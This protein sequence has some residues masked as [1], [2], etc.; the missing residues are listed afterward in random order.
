MIILDTNVVSETF[1]EDPDSHVA[2]WL[3]KQQPSSLRLCSITV[4]E[5]LYGLRLMPEGRKKRDLSILITRTLLK[6]NGRTLSFDAASA[7]NYAAIASQRKRAGHNVS[8]FDTQIAGIAAANHCS[9][10]TRNTK[11]FEDSGLDIINPWEYE[12]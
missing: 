3:K 7:N 10:A 8:I 9:I 12:G 1:K 4:A 2:Q 11:D 6:Y 5:L